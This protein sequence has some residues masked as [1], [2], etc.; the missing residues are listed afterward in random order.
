MTT[1]DYEKIYKFLA[2]KQ[3]KIITASDIAYGT[4]ISYV[5]GTMM[6]KLVRDGALEA[7]ANQGFYRVL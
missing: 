6:N 2:T 1:V 5:Y 7:C 3:G 4:G